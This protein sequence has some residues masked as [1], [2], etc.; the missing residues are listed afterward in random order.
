MVSEDGENFQARSASKRGKIQEGGGRINRPDREG[1][2]GGRDQAREVKRS[3]GDRQ[4]HESKVV[5]AVRF[6]G[7]VG[8]IR[9]V[10]LTE[11]RIPFDPL[12]AGPVRANPDS[13]LGGGWPVGFPRN[14]RQVDWPR[15]EGGHQKRQELL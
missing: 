2:E 5:A 12:E 7:V 14:E 9:P 4:R 10:G 1:I 3:M 6:L 13:N 11:Q 8:E 15:Q